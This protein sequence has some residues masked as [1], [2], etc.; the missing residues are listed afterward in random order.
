MQ[1]NKRTKERFPG[2]PKLDALAKTLFGKK[3]RSLQGNKK[4]K[5]FQDILG[6]GD[7]AYR[8]YLSG[9]RFPDSKAL[10]NLAK[11]TGV[12]LNWL[13]DDSQGIPEDGFPVFRCHTPPPSPPE[14]IDAN[15]VLKLRADVEKLTARNESLQD[16]LTLAQQKMKDA[17]Q[18]AKTAG[19]LHD[20]NGAAGA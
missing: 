7:T 12:D 2:R 13:L 20:T 3:L 18:A 19:Y 15:E 5:E 17:E 14:I 4:N 11:E 10:A 6:I 8:N 9:E 1:E 16:A